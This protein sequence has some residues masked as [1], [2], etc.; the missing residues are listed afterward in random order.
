MLEATTYT[1]IYGQQQL[2]VLKI[3]TAKLY[4]RKIFSYIFCVQKYFYNGRITVFVCTCDSTVQS[5]NEYT[6]DVCKQ[7]SLSTG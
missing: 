4:S 3:I 5:H 7:N 1:R 6:Y 2:F